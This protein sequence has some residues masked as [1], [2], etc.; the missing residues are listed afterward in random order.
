MKVKRE[1]NFE[2][3]RVICMLMII[4]GHTFSWGGILNASNPN[5][6]SMIYVVYAIILVEVNCF[7]LITGYFQS[8][9]KFKIKKFINLLF[10]TY[11]Y[12]VLITSLGYSLGWISL[13]KSE[14]LWQISPFDFS[15]YWFIK[16]YLVLYCLSPFINKFIRS[17]DRKTFRNLLIILFVFCSLL[18][19]LTNQEIFSN[20]AGY[21]LVQFVFMYLVGAYLREYIIN[22]K[23]KEKMY[24][25]KIE[26]AK[27]IFIAISVFIL[28]FIANYVLFRIGNFLMSKGGFTF[29]IGNRIK[30]V[31]MNYD[32]P[33]VVIGSVGF[34]MFF[35]LLRIKNRFINVLSATVFPVYLIHETAVFRP[36]LYSWFGLDKLSNIGSYKIFIWIAIIVLVIF[37]GCTIIDYVRKLGLFI[38]NKLI[39]CIQFIK[40]LK[41]KYNSICNKIDS[42]INV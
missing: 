4:T 16:I 25:D 5:I 10:L 17:I 3:L 21:S 40:P 24:K 7:I 38:L 20:S 15:N 36:I 41:N 37:I 31:F 18:V 23:I 35:S 19:T 27:N 32:N 14:F 28:C 42:W 8:K 22:D 11:F 9:S 29:L 33:L 39:N 2:L 30:S 34:F 26:L 1:S 13:S 6:A 12:K